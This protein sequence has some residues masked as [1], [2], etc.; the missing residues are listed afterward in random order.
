MGP[1]Q[2]KPSATI[3]P[4][5]TE[6]VR[7]VQHDHACLLTTFVIFGLSKGASVPLLGNSFLSDDPRKIR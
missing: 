5:L 3:R 2:P 6:K 4:S 7:Q 1:H